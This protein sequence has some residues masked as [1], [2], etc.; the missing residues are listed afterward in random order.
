MFAQLVVQ[1][2]FIAKTLRDASRPPEQR[3]HCCGMTLQNE[4]TGYSDLDKLFASQCDLEFIIGE[5]AARAFESVAI[6]FRCPS[7]EIVSIEKPEDYEKDSWQLSDE[8]K[9]STVKRFREEGNN[10]YREGKIEEATEKYRTAVGMIEQLLLKC[11]RR[12]RKC[13]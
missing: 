12:K 11:V 10:L 9:L 5:S 4:G 1:Y 2:P 7:A 13:R 3:K 6:T 8:E